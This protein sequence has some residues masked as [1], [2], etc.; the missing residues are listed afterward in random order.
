MQDG[1]RQ[2]AVTAHDGGQAKTNQRG[3]EGTDACRATQIGRL[4]W[5]GPPGVRE[6]SKVIAC[7]KC[8][9]RRGRS[10]TMNNPRH[11]RLSQPPG[12]WRPLTVV[13]SSLLAGSIVASLWA[14]GVITS[15]PM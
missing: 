2:Q 3:T 5:I 9:G 13:R 11:S 8:S 6:L 10:Y 15:V 4:D 14:T 7:G 1:E 12:K